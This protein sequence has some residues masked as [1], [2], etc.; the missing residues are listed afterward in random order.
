MLGGSGDP[1]RRNR[2]SAPVTS[3]DGSPPDDRARSTTVE[4]VRT[5]LAI[6][7]GAG[8]P[9]HLTLQAVAALGR[10]DVDLADGAALRA[11]LTDLRPT[12]VVNCA[13]YNF[14]DKAEAE[15]AAAFAV[16]V[17]QFDSLARSGRCSGRHARAHNRAVGKA[18]RHRE[19]GP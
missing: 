19:C 9:E 18:E 14:V 11:R 4:R 7:I 16:T 2:W 13:A 15:P 12:T 3:P 10:A 6:G 8:D 5:V 17:A 1:D